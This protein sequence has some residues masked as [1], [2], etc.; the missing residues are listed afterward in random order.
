MECTLPPRQVF[1]TRRAWYF[2]RKQ[3]NECLI[4]DTKNIKSIAGNQP[5][6]SN[7]KHFQSSVLFFMKGVKDHCR[8]F[9]LM[10]VAHTPT[11]LW[12]LVKTS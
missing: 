1:A 5:L 2:K 10:F 6:L 7:F 11:L 9:G 4:P 3:R 8:L 12:R